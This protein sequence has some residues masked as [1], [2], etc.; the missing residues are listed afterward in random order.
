MAVDAATDPSPT[1]LVASVFGALRAA[2][3]WWERSDRTVGLAEVVEK[4]L[5]LDQGPHD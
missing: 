2:V 5:A 3:M 1:L 4:A